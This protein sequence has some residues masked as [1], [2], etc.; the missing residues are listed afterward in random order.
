MTSESNITLAQ[1]QSIIASFSEGLAEELQTACLEA[2]KNL[3]W[4]EDCGF[5]YNY[6][7]G[8]SLSSIIKEEN[9]VNAISAVKFT[10][11]SHR[12][13]W[14]HIEGCDKTFHLNA[15]FQFGN[16]KDE[17]LSET[18][19]TNVYLQI[20]KAVTKAMKEYED[21]FNSYN[22]LFNYVAAA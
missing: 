10:F 4:K 7:G 15:A 6:A 5:D 17:N 11:A 14:F 18:R 19:E 12:N 8:V 13:L 1:I 21:M 20:A 2:R 16:I 22:T 3:F 9:R